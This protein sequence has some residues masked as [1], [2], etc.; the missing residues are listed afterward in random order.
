MKIFAI[1]LSCAQGSIALLDGEEVLEQ[2]TWIENFKDRQMLFQQLNDLVDDWEQIDLF[3]VGRGPGAFSGMRIAFSV[4]QSLAAPG[5]KPLYAL[6][7]GAALAVQFS[8]PRLAVLGD[9]RR[10]KVWAGLFQDGQLEGEFQLIEQ[11]EI[12]SF[13]PPQTPVVSP[14]AE[15]LKELLAPF[16]LITEEAVFPH[17]THL[18]QLVA[19][20]MHQGIASDPLEP[21]YMHP[22][23]FV[24]P[25][26]PA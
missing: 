25:R 19:R 8:S 26:F 14:D 3:A 10:G 12:A 1:E 2:R 5:N 15:R 24:A 6:N 23:V 22:P 7:S 13:I 18:G 9:A 20:R 21:L 4:A 16:S 17:A 11:E